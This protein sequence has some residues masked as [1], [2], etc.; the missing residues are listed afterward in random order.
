MYGK[1]VFADYVSGK[2]WIIPANFKAGRALPDPVADTDMLI[3]SFGEG[4]D[5]RLYVLDIGAGT[6][7][8]LDQS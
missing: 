1:Y 2:V 6:V 4:A 7:Y 5:G 8:R 3:S